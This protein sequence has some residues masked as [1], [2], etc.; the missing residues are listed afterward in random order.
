MTYFEHGSHGLVTRIHAIGSDPITFGYDGMLRRVRMSQG[1]V[2]TYFRHDGL[3]FI[4]IATSEGSLTRL[5]H[6]TAR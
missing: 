6:G 5:T 4:E 2:H 3:N 1:E